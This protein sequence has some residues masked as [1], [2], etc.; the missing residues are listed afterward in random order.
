MR[1]LT[2]IALGIP[3]PGVTV[4]HIAGVRRIAG[5][6]GFPIVIFGSRQTGFS[7]HTGLPYRE[8]SDIDLGI[9]GGP[10]ELMRLVDYLSEAGKYP[11]GVEHLPMAII[12]SVE[13]AVAR[14]YF[15]VLPLQG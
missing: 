6:L 5:R 2:G 13:E 1:D 12:N 3:G 14:G 11:P 8:E 10:G 15:V 7:A 9:V 4:R